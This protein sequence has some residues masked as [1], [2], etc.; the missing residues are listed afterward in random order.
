MAIRHADHSVAL[1]L[2]LGEQVRGSLSGIQNR[3]FDFA[4]AISNDKVRLFHFS[5]IPL[6]Y[7]EKMR[8]HRPVLNLDVDKLLGD[9]LNMLI[10][11]TYFSILLI[12]FGADFY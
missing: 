5:P 4:L 2:E 12:Y 6:C 8:I 9:L 1:G 11:I 7:D 10:T 3:E